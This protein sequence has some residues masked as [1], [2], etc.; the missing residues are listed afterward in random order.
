[1]ID[2]YAQPAEATERT[3]IFFAPRG[4]PPVK[5]ASPEKVATLVKTKKTPKARPKGPVKPRASKKTAEEGKKAVKSK[6][7]A[8]I[9]K[10]K[11]VVDLGQ[12]LI[13]PSGIASRAEQQIVMF[14]T[15]SQLLTG[16]SPNTLRQ[17]REA[18]RESEM[19]TS[20]EEEP[21]CTAP[22]QRRLARGIRHTSGKLWAQ[23][24]ESFD[25]A[26]A[27][28]ED[29]PSPTVSKGAAL[30]V[31]TEG[32]ANIFDLLRADMELVDLVPL[33]Y[34]DDGFQTL[35][36]EIEAMDFDND[37]ES[38]S[39]RGAMPG[40]FMPTQPNFEEQKASSWHEISSA[41]V[42]SEESPHNHQL[43]Q[44]DLEEG[45]ASLWHKPSSS[46]GLPDD[47]T[48]PETR[49]PWGE[50]N[51]SEWHTL[52]SPA[53]LREDCDSAGLQK[54]PSSVERAVKLTTKRAAAAPTMRSSLF[55]SLAPSASRTALRPLSTNTRSPKKSSASNKATTKSADATST[56]AAGSPKKKRGR[57]PKA[58]TSEETAALPLQST[59]KKSK[60][61]RDTTDEWHDIN[62]EIMD[63]EP[64]MTPSPR[65]RGKKAPSSPLPD[66]VS[67]ATEAVTKRANGVLA[68]ANHPQWPEIQATLFPDI[69]L[70]VKGQPRSTGGQR[71]SWYEKM[72]MYDPIVIE[73][74]TA[75]VNAEGLRITVKEKE[76]DIRGWMVQKWCEDNSV[77]CLWKE[78]LRGGVKTK[79]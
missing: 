64:D 62:D 10:P 38:P 27:D 65:H 34:T 75:F 32:E 57:P 44:P 6:V 2:K 22:V 23:Q 52:S 61:Q 31:A 12:K 18:L 41:Q 14:G 33:Q 42:L 45:E 16:D 79:Y 4:E 60:K 69:T 21:T 71:L 37:L 58:K 73:D 19:M 17:L 78:G 50:D 36:D 70:A 26:S 8:K 68:N 28:S 47:E 29:L 49:Q 67:N 39:N 40:G 7:K 54:S 46:P 72:L 51:A 77:C 9:T 74:L 53:A 25:E 55:T 35:S 30:T 63:S 5:T 24:A 11:K 1:M 59:P 20:I 43:R 76:E 3:S 48:R 13:S 56:D 15:S 66:L